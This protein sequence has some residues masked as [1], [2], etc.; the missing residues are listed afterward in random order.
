MRILLVED[1]DSLRERLSR[2]LEGE[3]YLVDAMADGAEGLWCA[4]E[5]P[6]VAAI[7]DLGLPKLDGLTLIRKLRESGNSCPVLVLTARDRWQDKVEGIETGADD[8]VT[9]PFRLEEVL[10][11]LRALIRRGAGYDSS[12]IRCGEIALDLSKRQVTLAKR[13]I[14]ITAFEYRV[15]SYLMLNANRVVSK[16]E[17]LD[18]LYGDDLEPDSNV[19][20]VLI[21][22]LRRKLAA[23]NQVSRIETL[24]GQGYRM[25]PD[26]SA[27][28]S[29]S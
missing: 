15:L 18:Q 1:D 24:R 3:G 5:Y 6:H 20:E 14:S 16:S 13:P 25:N 10:A 7:I 28:H 12:V 2:S 26:V 8:Y 27:L 17:L 4:T 22:R 11:R 21:A 19:L 29:A 23:D 9:K